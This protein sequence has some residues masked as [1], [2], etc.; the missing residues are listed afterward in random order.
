MT[1]E[2]MEFDVI[3]TGCDPLRDE[4][5]EYAHRLQA[6]GNEVDLLLCEGV[7]HGF[8]AMSNVVDAAKNA[9]AHAIQF[10]RRGFS[11]ARQAGGPS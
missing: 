5:L 3:V 1:R 6:E 9:I 11:D 4:D 10:L 8:L 7:P 2:A